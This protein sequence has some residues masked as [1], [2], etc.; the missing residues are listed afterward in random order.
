ARSSGQV[1][2]LGGISHFSSTADDVMRIY[3]TGLLEV[4]E[5]YWDLLTIVE[6][7][8]EGEPFSGDS[9]PVFDEGERSAEVLV[10]S[11]AAWLQDV[12]SALLA[13]VVAC[14][15][16]NRDTLFFTAEAFTAFERPANSDLVS[17]MGG[18]V[19]VG[20]TS[21]R[22]TPVGIP[23]NMVTTAAEASSMLREVLIEGTHLVL[24]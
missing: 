1:L 22:Q 12:L 3:G 17:I 11:G 8:Y 14:K 9:A 10:E 24:R 21:R 6:G 16:S 13:V 5:G 19:P 7:E 2:R 20:M 18:R 4:G 23:F 15:Q